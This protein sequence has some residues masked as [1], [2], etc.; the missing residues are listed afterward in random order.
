[1]FTQVSYGKSINW[2]M[3]LIPALL[4][5][6]NNVSIVFI[7]LSIFISIFY[8]YKNWDTLRFNKFDLI[9]T[10]CMS[11]YFLGAIPITIYDGTTARYFQGGIRLLLCLPIYFALKT[12]LWSHKLSFK[13][14]LELGVITGSIGAFGLAYYQHFILKMPRVDGFLFSIN[15][16]YLACAL[17]FLAF[18]FSFQSRLKIPLLL[19]SLLCTLAVVF[20]YTRGAI[21]AI[22]LLLVFIVILN[23]KKTKKRYIVIGGLSLSLAILA[24]YNSSSSFKSRMDYTTHE[25]ALIA[26][27]K[28]G[29]STSSGY[30]LQYWYGAFEAFKASPFIGLPYSQRE[31]LNHK[32]FLEGKI[33]KGASTITRG[34]A[35]SQYFEM[36]AGNG[37]L[38]VI[39]LLTIFA[40]PIIIFSLHY[41]KCNSHWALSAAVFVSGFAIYGLTE[42]PLTANLIGSFYG[43]MLAV[44]FAIVASEKQSGVIS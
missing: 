14:Y 43:F 9:V 44:F 3:F 5:T 28:V 35:H 38:G 21:F 32:L 10:L 37:L 23:F 18:T 27:G 12:Y 20:T 7:A 31:E 24:F 8:L 1:M 13:K 17:S 39:S 26:S 16:G 11:F 34:H 40:L 42:V 4:L 6:T 19:S 22:P 30:R 2:L 36:L 25:L 33:S 15:F 29:E 41:L